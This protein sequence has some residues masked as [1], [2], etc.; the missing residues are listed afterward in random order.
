MT[1]RVQDVRAAIARSARP[2]LVRLALVCL[3]LASPATRVAAEERPLDA[4][5][6]ARVERLAAEAVALQEQGRYEEA[7]ARLEE[8]AALYPSPALRY[9]IGRVHEKAGH[10]EEARGHYL[11]CLAADPPESLARR[12]RE[13]LE[14]TRAVREPRDEPEPPK[15]DVALRARPSA[16]RLPHLAL[17]VSEGL[18]AGGWSGAPLRSSVALHLTPSLRW[19]FVQVDLGLG[20]V[21]EPPLGFLLRP[22]VRL[23][24]GPIY[25]RVAY[26]LLA[27]DGVVTS[28]AVLGA[29]GQVDLAAGWYLALGLDVT[30]LFT[31]IDVVPLELTVGLGHGF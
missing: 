22:G 10:V 7:I 20:L 12:A 31:A 14:R 15:P 1:G 23:F 27:S 13:G 28:G 25:G 8:A 18:V 6:T 5:T 29:G 16:E 9:N 24:L 26:E 17:S 19:G 3:C 11:R 21:A 2:A 4:D 30:L